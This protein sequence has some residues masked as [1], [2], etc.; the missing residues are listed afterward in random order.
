MPAAWRFPLALLTFSLPVAAQTYSAPAGIRPALRGPVGTPASSILPG[1]RIITPLGEQHSTGSGP[2]GLVVSAS[3]KT[4]V[5]SNG[6]PGRNSL[7]I[8]ERGKGGGWEVGNLVA[9]SVD[10]LDEFDARDWRGV[11][12]GLALSGEHAVFASEGGSGRI[13]LFDWSTHRRRAIDLNQGGFDDSY[14]G[15]LALDAERNVLYAVDQANFRVAVIDARSRQV[16]ASVRVGRLPFA[17]AL[18][19]DRHKL[20]VTNLGMFEYRAIPGADPQ[21]ARA[22]GLPFPAFGFPSAEAA[23]G[24]ERQT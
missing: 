10:M 4:V 24:V 1:G 5:T 23:A 17:L 16:L 6:G 18:S 19:P 2:F 7:T 12:M 3:G 21:Q 20:Y 14:T 22:T 9:R 15:D 13:S 8:M 11:F